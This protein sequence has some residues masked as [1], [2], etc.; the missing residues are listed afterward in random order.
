M[1]WYTVSLMIR[2]LDL[3]SYQDF[4][5]MFVEFKNYW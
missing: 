4:V 5:G 1:L 3:G 2:M